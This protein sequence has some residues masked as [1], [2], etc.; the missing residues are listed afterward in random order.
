MGKIITDLE[1]LD[2]EDLQE[3][4]NLIQKKAE[5]KQS[6]QQKG[7]RKQ[8][9][10]PKQQ[11]EQAPQAR[12]VKRPKSGGVMR[13]ID[14][15]ANA[16][17]R[18]RPGRR[19]GGEGGTGRIPAVGQPVEKGQDGSRF[20]TEGYSDLHRSK[21]EQEQDKLLA[22]DNRPTLRRNPVVYREV[23]CNHCGHW[24]EAPESLIAHDDEGT[25]FVCPDCIRGR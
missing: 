2:P 9:R 25:I 8:R 13:R 12:P 11:A 24:W 22:G 15:P 7:K 23:E 6:P 14:K 19:G 4:L 17:S 5:A 21:K 3:V 1:S 10:K 16:R 18:R 20:I